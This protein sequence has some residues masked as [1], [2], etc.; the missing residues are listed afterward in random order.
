MKL[1][2]NSEHKKLKKILVY[3]QETIS[4]EMLNRC[5]DGLFLNKMYPLR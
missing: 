5:G 3:E 4:N 1:L 2:S